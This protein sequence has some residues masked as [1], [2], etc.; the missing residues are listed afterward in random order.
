[1]PLEDVPRAARIRRFQHVVALPPQD[2]AHDYSNRILVFHQ[3]NRLAAVRPGADF[4]RGHLHLL[5]SG[6][7]REMNGK[8]RADARLALDGDESIALAYDAVNGRQTETSP[9][10]NVLRREEGFEQMGACLRRN[11]DAV[12]DDAH[13]DVV[14]RHRLHVGWDIDLRSTYARDLQPDVAAGRQRVACVQHEVED[15]LLDL[16]WI[17]FDGR[18]LTGQLARQRDVLSNEAHQHVFET[19]DGLVEV[20]VFRHQDLFAAER[21][22]LLRE[23]RGALSRLLDFLEI[24]A[25]GIGFGAVTD[26]QLGIAKD[27]GQQVVE[28][29]RD[30]A[31]EASD[32][33]D[34]FGLH[35]PLFELT[36]VGDVARDAEM[37]IAMH[38]DSIA[39]LDQ[40]RANGAR[41]HT[42][43][44]FRFA[45]RQQLAPRCDELIA[46]FDQQ[47][48]ERSVD[49]TFAIEAEQRARRRIGFEDRAVVVEDQHRVGR[50]EEHRPELPRPLDEGGFGLYI[51]G[52]VDQE[53][54]EL[55][56]FGAVE[57]G[58]RRFDDVDDGVVAPAQPAAVVLQVSMLAQ[59]GNEALTLR[60]I[61]EDVAHSVA[62][63]VVHRI[64]AK[65][66]RE[67]TVAGDQ[68]AVRSGDVDGEQRTFEQLLIARRQR[69]GRW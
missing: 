59:A 26:Q 9:L 15:R 50:A 33:L 32:A 60:G 54:A 44:A 23:R 46:S 18:G 53:S 36:A 30:A 10:A 56:E 17:H 45:E 62:D 52:H 34:L 38:A 31:G 5:A 65:H 2:R 25:I 37:A 24:R 35:Q 61:G 11:P 69:N 8:G 12:I 28:I 55:D 1:M 3:Q 21:E 66:A 57:F 43:L 63:G 6:D 68:P 16:R 22:Q 27:C 4:D 51:G 14:A 20:H 48:V 41:D 49:Q 42:V 67:R 13:P 19:G 58:Y 29:V 40:A 7:R 39:A 47:A 64:E